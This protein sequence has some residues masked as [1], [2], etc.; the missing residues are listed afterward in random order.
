MC[1]H[2]KARE[3]GMRGIV[4]QNK[5]RNTFGKHHHTIFLHVHTQIVPANIHTHRLEIC[6]KSASWKFRKLWYFSQICYDEVLLRLSFPPAECAHHHA[7]QRSVVW[8]AAQP[9]FAMWA[10]SY[11]PWRGTQHH[12]HTPPTTAPTNRCWHSC[13]CCTETYTKALIL[14]MKIPL[15]KGALPAFCGILRHHR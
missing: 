2:T 5:Y 3:R 14:S 12:Q 9:F 15:S 7:A 4:W 10:T 8:S 6:V 1:T 11:A 13:V